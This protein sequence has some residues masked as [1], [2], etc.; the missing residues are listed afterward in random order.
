MTNIDELDARILRVLSEDGRISNLDLS[1]KVGLSPSACLRRV[2]ELERAGVIRGYRAVL[3]P[4]RMGRG[5]VALVMVGLNNH[6][7]AS[8]EDFER[9]MARADEVI[10]CLNITGS[11]EYALRVECADLA[12]YKRFHSDIL[13]RLPQVNSITT[14]VVMGAPKDLRR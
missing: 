5:F 13:G 14:H 8:Q 7:T 1:E 11:V 6:S 4:E 3:D 2:R 12:A 10:E 9:A